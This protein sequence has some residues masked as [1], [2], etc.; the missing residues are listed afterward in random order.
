MQF[1]KVVLTGFRDRVPVDSSVHSK[2]PQIPFALTYAPHFP[3][4]IS[5]IPRRTPTQTESKTPTGSCR[6]APDARDPFHCVISQDRPNPTPPTFRSTHRDLVLDGI[7]LRRS[8]F[9]TRD[10]DGDKTREPA[11]LFQTSST[12][13]DEN[14]RTPSHASPATHDAGK[15]F[16]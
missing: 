1:P 9:Q 5:N 4:L 11:F 16:Q 14:I 2:S 13:C 3:F 12:F 15:G 10:P 6:F 8:A 7:P